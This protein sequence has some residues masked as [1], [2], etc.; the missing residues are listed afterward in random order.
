MREIG[1]V[2]PGERV[3]QL[4]PNE[5]TLLPDYVRPVKT[6]AVKAAEPSW[7][8]NVSGRLPEFLA[9]PAFVTTPSRELLLGMSGVVTIVAFRIYRRR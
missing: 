2:P 5:E 7:L 6:P 8:E 4:R 1:F 3:V 9:H